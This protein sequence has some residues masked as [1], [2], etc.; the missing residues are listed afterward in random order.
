MTAAPLSEHSYV[1]RHECRTTKQVLV[2]LNPY[3][4][5]DFEPIDAVI[6]DISTS[7]IGLISYQLLPAGATIEIRKDGE[8]ISTAEVANT[9]EWNWCGIVRMGLR[10]Q[11]KTYNWPWH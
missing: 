8:V 3:N 11:N 5:G 2:K 6:T 4:R 9:V 10:L 1:P 7:G